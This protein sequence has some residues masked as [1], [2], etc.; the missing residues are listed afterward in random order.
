MSFSL[1]VIW[2]LPAAAQSVYV[3]GE[4]GEAGLE[5]VASVGGEAVCRRK[6]GNHLRAR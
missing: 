1:T 6:A 2:K 3:L 4:V 5:H